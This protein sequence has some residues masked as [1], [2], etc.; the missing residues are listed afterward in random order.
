MEKQIERDL[1]MAGGT[2]NVPK[3]KRRMIP[4]PAMGFV[5]M[6]SFTKT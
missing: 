6:T 2:G 1:E 5:T 4:L 3:M